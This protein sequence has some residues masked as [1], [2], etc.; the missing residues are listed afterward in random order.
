M[1]PTPE[2]GPPVPESIDM[3][4]CA[5]KE[6]ARAITAE[7]IRTHAITADRVIASARPTG[8]FPAITPPM[9][10]ERHAWLSRIVWTLVL[11][12][13]LAAVLLVSIELIWR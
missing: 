12:A 2:C 4:G 6:Q 1:K 10:Y 5:S 9:P 3:T 7:S 8:T 11:A 13:N